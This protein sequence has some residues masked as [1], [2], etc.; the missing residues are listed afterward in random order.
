[1]KLLT[2]FLVVL[3]SGSCAISKKT[4]TKKFTDDEKIY[5]KNVIR[6]SKQEPVSIVKRKSDSYIVLEFPT[7]MWVLK[8]SGFIDKYYELVDGE[9]IDYGTEED[10]Y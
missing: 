8:P 9:W 7:Q 10:A 4:Y 5:I 6:I 1:M 2:I 3:L